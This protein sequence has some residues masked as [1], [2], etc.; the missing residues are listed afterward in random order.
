MKA[1]IIANALNQ[2]M[3]AKRIG[4]TELV[5]NK[6]SKL[7]VGLFEMMKKKGYIDYVVDGTKVSVSILDLNEC[8]AIKPRYYV[9]V[10]E[11]DKYLRRYLPSRNFGTIVV[12]TNTGLVSHKEAE[13][14]KIGGALI[15]YFF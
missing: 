2:I 14:K 5:I 6:H 7:L 15:A 10:S 12:S 1:D 9:G 4:K 3:N 8:R 11:I 13:E